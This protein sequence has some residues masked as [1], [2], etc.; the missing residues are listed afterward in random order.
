MKMKMKMRRLELEL[1][2]NVGGEGTFK[3]EKERLKE[4]LKELSDLRG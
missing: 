1:M 3:E 4:R 2:K